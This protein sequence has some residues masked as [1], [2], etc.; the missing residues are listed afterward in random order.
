MAITYVLTEDIHTVDGKCYIFYGISALEGGQPRISVR[1]V[2]TDRRRV[3]RLVEDCN[4]L[5]LSP[6][7]LRDVI[8]DFL[9]EER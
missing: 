8:E 1:D 2:C 5:G 3:E 4:R 6:L 7:H 9:L